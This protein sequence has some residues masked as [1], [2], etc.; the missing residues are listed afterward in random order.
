MK[1]TNS[2]CYVVDHAIEDPDWELN[3]PRSSARATATHADTGMLTVF[4]LTAG[5]VL[6]WN[7]GIK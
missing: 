7:G 1:K 5:K 3:T 4:Y 2:G 6:K